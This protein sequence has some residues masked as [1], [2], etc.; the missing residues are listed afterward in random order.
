MGPVSNGNRG[1]MGVGLLGLPFLDY[2]GPNSLASDDHPLFL[3][4]VL[5]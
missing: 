3:G 1:G 2:F 4:A 5:N